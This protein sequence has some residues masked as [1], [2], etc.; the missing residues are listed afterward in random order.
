[1]ALF[2]DDRKSGQVM[3]LTLFVM[4]LLLLLGEAV[5]LAGISVQRNALLA[6]RQK[7]A[8]YIAEAGINQAIA[9]IAGGRNNVASLVNES[10]AGG[11]VS[12]ASYS[13]P[14][15]DVYTVNCT[16]EYPGP[17]DRAGSIP[18]Y[19][20]FYTVTAQFK[21]NKPVVPGG[22]PSTVTMISWQ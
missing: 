18:G 10:Y 22:D 5:L 1:M 6:T 12:A 4:M 3:V 16:G 17:K 11:I 13:G 20:S 8:Y 14:V 2:E 19:F 15:Q 7:Q 9:M 21:L